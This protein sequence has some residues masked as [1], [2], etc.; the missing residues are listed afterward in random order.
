MY[1]ILEQ[2]GRCTHLFVSV[3]LSRQDE[4]LLTKFL[5]HYLRKT[6][7]YMLHSVTLCRQ[8]LFLCHYLERQNFAY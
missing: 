4:F 6:D 5:Q 3:I 7:I 8:T 2:T 1:E